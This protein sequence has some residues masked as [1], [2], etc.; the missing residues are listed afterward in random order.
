MNFFSHSL[1]WSLIGCFLL[2]GCSSTKSV[3]VE[4]SPLDRW[5]QQQ[6]KEYLRLVKERP[7]DFIT[8]GIGAQNSYSTSLQDA[9]FNSNVMMPEKI[10]MIIQTLMVSDEGQYDVSYQSGSSL[11]V[12]NIRHEEIG[13]FTYMGKT[14][15]SVISAKNKKEY[16]SEYEALNTVASAQRN[17]LERVSQKVLNHSGDTQATANWSNQDEVN[18]WSESSEQKY[19]TWSNKNGN[20]ISAYAWSY[21]NDYQTA[22][23][24]AKIMAGSFLPE[25]VE[26]YVEVVTQTLTKLGYSQQEITQSRIS[27]L[28]K[29]KKM[30]S[31]MESTEVSKTKMDGVFL[32][33]VAVSRPKKEF[34]DV[35]RSSVDTNTQL[36]DDFFESAGD[37]LGAYY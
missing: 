6:N 13:K 8:L 14:Y 10:G 4:S 29:A 11:R 2:F 34:D 20:M 24:K 7:S 15:V 19:Q 27:S 31:N 36:D 9:K 32:V 37:V 3:V 16:F 12:D 30:V 5:I 18:K 17:A 35:I 1:S 23:N 21:D 25:K 26:V 28:S 33:G 22:F